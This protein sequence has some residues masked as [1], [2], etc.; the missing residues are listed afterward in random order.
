MPAR[1]PN[2]ALR[3]KVPAYRF[4]CSDYETKIGGQ[5]YRLHEGEWVEIIPIR[6][7]RETRELLE[8]RRLKVKLDAVAGEKDAYNRT[9]EI[10]DRTY[11]QVCHTLSERVVAWNWT[12][13]LGRPLPQPAGDPEVLLSLSESE[14]AY[15]VGL[16]QE[17]RPADQGKDLR[18]SPT[19][20][21][22][23]RRPK[24]RRSATG[25]SRTR[26]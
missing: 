26:G 11:E 20:S 7:A 8:L 14:I 21:S 18:R 9:L 1:S 12:D 2:G 23:T 17:E 5:A 10:L 4:D 15:L 22:A 19:T 24:T 16:A 6:S 13:K 25:R 3:P